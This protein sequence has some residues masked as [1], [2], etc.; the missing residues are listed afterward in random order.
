M[1][2]IKVQTWKGN[3]V[4]GEWNEK[5]YEPLVEG[6][7]KGIWRIYMNNERYHI[8]EDEK[9]RLISELTTKQLEKDN[10]RARIIKNEFNKLSEEGR[11]QVLEYLNFMYKCD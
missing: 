2:Q 1:K 3:I 6:N 5:F 8:K 9:E 11:K 4:E 7:S 10:E